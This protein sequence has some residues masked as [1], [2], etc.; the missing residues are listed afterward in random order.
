MH[1]T[2]GTRLGAYEI[3][4]PI[5]SGGMGE[6]YRAHDQRVGRDVAIKVLPQRL[7]RDDD[8]RAR[9]TREAKAVAAISH[10]NVLALYEFE[11]E[12]ELSYVVTELLEGDTLRSVL[13]HGPMSWRR[14]AEVAASIADGLA[15]AHAK[16]IVHRDL[17]PENIFITD[18]GLVK[19]LDFGLARARLLPAV[20]VDDSHPTERLHSDELDSDSNV[21]GTVGYMSP[22]QLRAEPVSPATDL[23]ALGCILFECITGR[24]AFRSETAIDTMTAVLRDDLPPISES[25]Q[26]IPY[27]LDRIIH[28]CVEKKPAARFQSARD[29]AFALRQLTA[30]GD[31]DLMKPRRRWVGPLITA[32][33]SA[34]ALAVVFIKPTPTDAPIRSIAVLPFANDTRDV[35]NDYLTDGITEM[36]ISDLAGIPDLSVVSRASV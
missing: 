7:A 13:S 34:I 6:V 29:L 1:L 35:N 33:V 4:A 8:A 21:I 31:V 15:A 25:G 22:E 17:K 2:P 9:L 24:G 14:A 18:E 27:E 32:V 19:I 28:R 26:R 36:L 23:F 10:P 16:G 11:Q 3:V 5:A 20:E 12:G 30:S